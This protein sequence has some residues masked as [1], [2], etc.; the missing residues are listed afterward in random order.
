MP[1]LLF[2]A[3]RRLGHDRRGWLLQSGLC[4]LVLPLGYWVTEPER[5]INWVF[6]P[7]GMDQVWLPPAVYVLLCMLAY[8]LLLYLPAEWLLR[9]L[10]PRARPAGV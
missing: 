8:P 7:F 4:W 6:A 9:R 2:L 3:L 10:L 5:N 1:L